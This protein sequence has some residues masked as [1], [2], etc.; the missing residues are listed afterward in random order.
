MKWISPKEQLGFA[1]ELQKIYLDFMELT[2]LGNGIAVLESATTDYRQR[3]SPGK[4]VGGTKEE[5]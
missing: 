5:K 2:S 4:N 1:H 3:S